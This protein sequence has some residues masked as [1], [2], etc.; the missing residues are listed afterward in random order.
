[1][2][3]VAVPD[4]KAAPYGRAAREA[5]AKSGVLAAVEPKLVVG[6]SVGQTNQ[7]VA[8]G[9]ADAGLTAKSTVFAP[10][11]AGRGRWVEVPADLHAPIEQA[12]VVLR[13]GREKN[14]KAVDRLA[15]FLLSAEAR[16]VWS[17][18]GYEPAA[19]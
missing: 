14:P 17:K 10:Q 16:A 5:L 2:R 13:H 15:E 12:F 1:M 8:S 18:F 9:A 19:P 6:E 3:K 11:T 4:P 7:F